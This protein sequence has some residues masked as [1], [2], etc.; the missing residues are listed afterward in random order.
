[1]ASKLITEGVF[2]NGVTASQSRFLEDGVTEIIE[3]DVSEVLFNAVVREDVRCVDQISQILGGSGVF[4]SGS[5]L[6]GVDF[7]E[8]GAEVLEGHWFE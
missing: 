2:K 5:L 4:G 1:M 7:A 6:G 3:L 8:C